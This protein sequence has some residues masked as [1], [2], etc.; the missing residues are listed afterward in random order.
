MRIERMISSEV[1]SRDGFHPIVWRGSD[2]DPLH[3]DGITLF[4]GFPAE[5]VFPSLLFNSGVA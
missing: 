1:V 3:E 2:R 5:A 4:C